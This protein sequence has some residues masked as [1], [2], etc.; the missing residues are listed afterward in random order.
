M[1]NFIKRIFKKEDPKTVVNFVDDKY[2]V[3]TINGKSSI[4]LRR[5][6]EEI[7][8][9]PFAIIIKNKV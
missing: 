2:V 5:D 1:F 6:Y 8:P 4:E 3:V 9:S 7:N